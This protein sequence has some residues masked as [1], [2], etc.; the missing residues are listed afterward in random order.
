MK[1]KTLVSL[2][3]LG[4]VFSCY[5]QQKSYLF[6]LDQNLTFTSRDSALIIGNGNY[7][8]GSFKLDCYN[9]FS[10]KL[11]L[12]LHSTDTTLTNLDGRFISYFE[13][14][15]I[16]NEGYYK[17]NIID[18]TWI[19]RDSTGA[20]TDSIKYSNGKTITHASFI[21]FKNNQVSI[22]ELT[23]SI[24]NT[25]QYI[26]FD[27]TGQK[28]FDANFIG[29]NGIYSR[30]D[31]SKVAS[32]NVF[33]REIVEADCSEWLD[34][35]RKNLHSNIPFQRGA[36]PGAYT[37]ITKFTIEINGNISTVIP[38]THFGFGMEDEAMRVIKRGP[39]WIPASLFGIPVKSVRRQ[40]ITF[41]FN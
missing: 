41:V 9:K 6:F 20:V 37:T 19:T 35:I 25:Y 13:N 17:K 7:E 39:K 3:F 28:I 11:I 40:P 27:S 4:V 18:S 21:Y 24:K 34:Y 29:D 38:E 26:S 15:L 8:A 16:E 2:F 5:A 23:D 10:K 36:T 1:Y 22:Y 32:Q 30:Y 33:S 31:S 12:T 14:G